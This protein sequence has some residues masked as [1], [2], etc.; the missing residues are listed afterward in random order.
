M[1]MWTHNM[2]WTHWKQVATPETAQEL[3]FR[4]FSG[5]AAQKLDDTVSFVRQVVFQML[6]NSC[7]LNLLTNNPQN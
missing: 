4:Y 2:M 1:H 6:R 7:V 5:I 3:L